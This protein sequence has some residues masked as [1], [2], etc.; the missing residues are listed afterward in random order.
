MQVAETALLP[1]LRANPDAIVLAEE[2]E[3][4][5][6]VE[7]ALKAYRENLSLKAAA[8]AL[9]YVSEQEFDPQER[10][11]DEQG[12]PRAASVVRTCQPLASCQT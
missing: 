9:N 1:A 6:D 3:R 10:F 2:L 8:L 7:T 12:R 4:N 11:T 5:A